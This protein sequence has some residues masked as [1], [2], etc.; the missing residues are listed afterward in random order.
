[1]DIKTKLST[2]WIFVIINYLFNDIFS[3][4]FVPGVVDEALGF[5]GGSWVAP[6]FFAVV[7]EA[8]F[9]MVVL[10]Q[11]LPYAANRWANIVIGALHMVLAV[12]SLVETV[13]E[14]FYAFIVT[15]EI[16]GIL[17]IIWYA[18]RWQNPEVG[19]K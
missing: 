19:T 5:T 13:P 7:L 9:V 12:W 8:A 16:I 3:L 11:I 4:Y 10:S 2:L 17:F 18:W 14:P 1:M 15:A 6:L